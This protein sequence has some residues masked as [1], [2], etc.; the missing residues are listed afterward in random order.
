MKQPGRII[1][2]MV[3]LSI[4]LMMAGCHGS[5][6]AVGTHPSYEGASHGPPPWAPAHGYRAK[7]QY[8]YYPAS[9]VYFDNGRGLYFYYDGGNW[10]VSASLPSGI[11]IA[12]GEYVTLEMDTGKPYVFHSDV[13][14]KYPPGQLKKMGKVKAKK[15]WK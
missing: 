2:L 14:K 11:H 15:N 3:G 13:V 5:R 7:Y 6:I 10:R 4:I 12:V 1:T 9:Q 8:H